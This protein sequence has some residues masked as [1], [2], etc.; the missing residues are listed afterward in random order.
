MTLKR[1]EYWTS[2]F[3]GF[4]AALIGNGL[5]RFAYTPLIPALIAENWFT[6]SEA[7]YL[8]A[9]N[10]AGYLAGALSGYATTR[11]ARPAA[12]MR[13]MMLLTAASLFAC[14][15]RGLGFAWFF[16]WRFVAGYTGGVLIVVGAPL[17]LSVTPH[18]RR[19]VVG[20]LMFTGVGLGI[21]IS[22]IVVPRLIGWG[23]L[24]GTWFGLGAIAF[25]LALFAWKGWPATY[26]G[27]APARESRS[28]L[29]VPVYAL[30][31]YALLGEYALNAIGL[32][33]HML[34]LVDY[35]ARGLGRG[36]DAGAFDWIVFGIAAALG[37]ILS[38]RLADAIGFRAAIL[39]AFCAQAIAVA[40][41]VITSAPVWIA[42]SSA[43]TGACVPG[44]STLALGRIHELIGAGPTQGRAWGHATSAWAITQA[45]AAYG[46]AY[47]LGKTEDY[48]LLF[49]IG[50]AALVLALVLEL[51]LGRPAPMNRTSS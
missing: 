19:G 40:L 30:P 14:M 16:L 11:V 34:F 38:G 44:I 25:V 15:E 45:L 41:P 29:A 1:R 39:L 3:A 10:L 32:V 33:P 21:A 23:G 7:G 28:G 2:A 22:G 17:L 12:I 48:A 26:G 31:V 18:D 6:A 46:Y 4:C 47:L 35:V 9:A 50:V 49:E 43:V 13:N 37:P 5:G 36:L 27:T 51:A 24:D 42:V 20:G 8:G